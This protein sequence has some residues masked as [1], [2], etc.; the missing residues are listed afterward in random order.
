MPRPDHNT[1]ALLHPR[2]LRL[3]IAV[4]GVGII[5][6]LHRRSKQSFKR[7]F[8]AS[9][10]VFVDRLYRED[11]ARIWVTQEIERLYSGVPEQDIQTGN[12]FDR[13]TGL[14]ELRYRLSDAI[15]NEVDKLRQYV[16][17]HLEHSADIVEGVSQAL[18]VHLNYA[19]NVIEGAHITEQQ[20][21]QILTDQP[22][23]VD[24]PGTVITRH[25]VDDVIGH[26]QAFDRV[27]QIGE[28][29]RRYDLTL[30]DV[31]EIHRLVMR[32]E[33]AKAGRFRRRGEASSIRGEKALL[34]H[35]LEVPRLME[36]AME[37]LTTS[38]DHV[39]EIVTNVHMMFVRIHPCVDGNGR[40]IRLLCCLLLLQAGYGVLDIQP[41]MK[42][43]YV[44]AIHTWEAEHNPAVFG[45]LM[46][47]LVINS[48]RRY[49][50]S[51]DSNCVIR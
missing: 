31:L 2:V 27:R 48:L 22:I 29:K 34:A 13:E 20:T 44:K 8:L 35:P 12:I 3:A 10:D 5:A 41:S 16:S 47:R 9:A 24:T 1:L 43:Q 36:R 46:S 25:T 51:I 39:L 21:Q 28:Q 38:D 26:Q 15:R 49:K 6:F 23:T 4:A 7:Q 30:E 19:S 40:S 45:D 14:F 50:A 32:A 42:D 17:T 18:G 33:P 37:Y 11:E